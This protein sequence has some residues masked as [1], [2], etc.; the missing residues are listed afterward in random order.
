MVAPFTVTLPCVTDICGGA[1][2]VP[3]GAAVLEACAANAGAVTHSSV[4]ANRKTYKRFMC[5]SAKTTGLFGDVVEMSEI[6]F[7]PGQCRHVQI[8]HVTG[9]VITVT[10]VFHQ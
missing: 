9:L 5:I 8:D 1:A 7:V 6:R 2:V 3:V 10:D 4:I